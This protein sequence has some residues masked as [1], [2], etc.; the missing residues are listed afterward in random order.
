MVIKDFI[1]K[2]IEKCIFGIA[3]C[4]LVY[5]TIHTYGM[6][7]KLISRA[8]IIDR[9]LETST[10]PAIDTELKNAAELELRLTTPPSAN[11]LQ[12]PYLLSKPSTEAVLSDMTAEG[13]LKKAE[14]R[15]PPHLVVTTPGDTEFIYKGGTADLALIQV[16]KLYKDK[17][18]VRS[19]AVEKGKIIGEKN[20]IAKEPLD[21]NTHC[22]LIEIIPFAQR[23]LVVKKTAVLRDEKG[24]FLGTTL[25]EETHK[26]STSRIVF[27][28]DKGEPYNLWIGELVNLGK[29]TVNITSKTSTN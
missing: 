14:S 21:F 15:T 7:K 24:E 5:S 25:T 11:P 4:Y 6:N 16:R 9:K 23:P 17:W 22:K 13:L 3:V 1:F 10:P 12:R 26:I 29:E 27:E 2:H 20:L 8:S 19:F 28:N 18:R